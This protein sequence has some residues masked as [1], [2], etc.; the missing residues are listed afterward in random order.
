MLCSLTTDECGT[1]LNTAL[2]HTGNDLCN[3]L[4]IVLAASNIVKEKQNLV[5][6]GTE[7]SSGSMRITDYELQQK[8]FE[9]LGMTDEEIQAKFGFLVDAYRYGAPPHGGMGIGLDRI[10]MIMPN[11]PHQRHGYYKIKPIH[12]VSISV[13]KFT[14]YTSFFAKISNFGVSFFCPPPVDSQLIHTRI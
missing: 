1:G 6:N 7:L 13:K 9:A 14:K 4:G 10:A 11:S 2:S 12:R 5:L 8:M 3:L